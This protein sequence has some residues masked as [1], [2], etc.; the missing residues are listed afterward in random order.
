MFLRGGKKEVH[1]IES[2]K[3][4]QR[5]RMQDYHIYRAQP[6]VC[7]LCN[8]VSGPSSVEPTDNKNSKPFE[9]SPQYRIERDRPISSTP[10]IHFS[11]VNRTI[12]KCSRRP[13][14]S[15]CCNPIAPLSV[16][17]IYCQLDKWLYILT[18]K[19]SLIGVRHHCLMSSTLLA[20]HVCCSLHSHLQ[21]T[22]I[23]QIR[24]HSYMTFLT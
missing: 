5:N 12:D 19:L 7:T 22:G 18:S 2:Q 1:S 6:I 3:S 20:S 13:P 4:P 17:S 14:V 23:R 9:K 8:H 16:R 15:R 11:A 24:D 21:R 10:T